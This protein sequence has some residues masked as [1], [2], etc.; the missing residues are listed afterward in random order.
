MPISQALNLAQEQNLDLVEI[1]T[2][3]KPPITKIMDFGKFKYEQRKRL[4]ESKKNQKNT[5]VKEVWVKPF[6]E[7]NDLNVKLKKIYEFLGDGNK[8]KISIMTRG[9]KRVLSQGKDVIPELFEKIINIV[10]DKGVLESRSKP[11]ERTKSILISPI[12]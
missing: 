11:N 8:V 1:N 5:S 6:I 7:E 3:A 9:S 12:K 10:K 2:N 4:S